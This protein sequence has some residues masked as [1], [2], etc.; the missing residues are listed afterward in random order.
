LI[1]ADT[2]I[3]PEGKAEHEL[4]EWERIAKGRVPP[5]DAIALDDE[6][7]AVMRAA[8]EGHGWSCHRRY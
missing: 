1:P 7:F 5:R 4:T 2:I 8:H 6:T 3:N